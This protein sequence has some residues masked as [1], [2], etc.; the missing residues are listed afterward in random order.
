VNH[1][2]TATDLPADTKL[3]L[4]KP[5]PA[6]VVA[7]RLYGKA[8]RDQELIDRNAIQHPLYAPIELTAAAR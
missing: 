3:R 1:H 7:Y 4:N 6:A 8:D 5:L 2:P